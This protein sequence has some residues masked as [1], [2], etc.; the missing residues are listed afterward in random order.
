MSQT[1]TMSEGETAWRGAVMNGRVIVALIF[2]E[3][4]L[5]FGA[6][7]IAYVW[8]M[9]EPTL[10]VGLM[11][12]MRIYIKNYAP[13]FGES[14]TLF[15]LTGLISFRI[16][17]NT[18]N[19]AGKAIGSNQS[20]FGFGAVKPPDVVIARTVVEF[21]IW[22]LVLTFFFILCGRL[23]QIEMISNFQDFVLALAAMFY[24][25]LAMSMFNATFGALVPL[26]RTIW[27][28][29]TLPLLFASGVLYVPSSMPPE[30]L[31]I[32]WWNPFLH[33]IEAL[34]SSSYLDYLSLYSP[35]YLMSFTTAVLLLSLAVERLFR[36][37]IIRSK[38]DDDDD[39]DVL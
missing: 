4:A 12:L 5:R 31:N 13:A 26:W 7:P 15:L 30:V 6:G 22:L 25:C 23:L 18:I 16:T 37:E 20:L 24:F 27:K 10:L 19:K 21:T 34:R 38:N 32:I 29:M 35:T 1:T 9:V 8:T 2:R 39:E 11:L 36:K 28:I 17:R 14:S 3:A 33:C